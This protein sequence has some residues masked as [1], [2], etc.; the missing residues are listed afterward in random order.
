MSIKRILRKISN[1]ITNKQSSNQY[2]RKKFLKSIPKNLK[3]LEIGPFYTPMQ[4]G[5]NVKYF[6]V[7]DRE[8]LVE[9][10]KKLEL[11][12]KVDN[13]P[14][15]DFVSPTAD[16]TIVD[17]KFD[18]IFSSHVIEH[19][20]DLIDHLQKASNLLSDGGKYYL[21]I[22]DKRYCFDHYQQTS[23]IAD[24]IIA[25]RE[26]R[27]KHSLK[28]VLEHRAFLTHNVSVDHWY[29]KH[30]ELTDIATNI[31]NA[32]EEY[33]AKDYIDVHSFFFTPTS[34]VEIMKLLHELNYINFKVARV[35]E[36][37][38]NNIEFCCVLE[39][40]ADKN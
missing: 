14:H 25:H 1:R 32:I 11:S 29:G 39:K 24:V 17:E 23:T 7:L 10:A 35:H 16:L 13:I 2:D 6:D 33:E 3:I 21:I 8:Q 37:A 9:R 36:T 40:E 28:N 30:G 5:D 34:F 20:F 19:Q 12:Y 38:I 4:K 18:A 27:K 15:I 26:K 22:P 31:K